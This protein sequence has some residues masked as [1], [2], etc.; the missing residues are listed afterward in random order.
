MEA[1]QMIPEMRIAGFQVSDSTHDDRI[2]GRYV[3][4][5]LVVFQPW[6]AFDLYGADYAEPFGDLTISVR[7]RGA[8]EY[9]IVFGRPRNTLRPGWIKEMY[10]GID[11]R[12]LCG[13]LGG[14]GKS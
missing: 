2:S 7:Q 3:Q 9:G 8:V 11:N 1:G 12:N 4:N 10:V 13:L 5:P 14:S 6:A